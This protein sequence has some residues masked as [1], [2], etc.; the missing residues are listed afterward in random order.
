[1]AAQAPVRELGIRRR[2]AGSE[3][4][5]QDWLAVEAPLAIS[6]DH[7]EW[8]SPQTLTVT[9]RTPGHDAELAL[10][11][12]YAEG[13]LDL[14]APVATRL[15]APDQLRVELTGV[16]PE[17]VALARNG[18]MHGGCGVC[19]KLDA[20]ALWRL[21]AASV[22]G[23]RRLPD[24]VLRAA[25]ATLRAAQQDYA[26]TGGAHAVAL[27]DYQGQLQALREDIGRHNA[28]DKLIGAAYRAGSL[29]WQDQLLLLSGRA[30]AELIHKAWRAGA[31]VVAAIGAPS[32]LAVSLAEQAGITLIGFLRAD[33]YNVYTH[34]ERLQ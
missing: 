28:L 8:P 29:P 6:V 3:A 5:C 12:L 26:Q 31:S 22:A 24:A 15:V 10:G 14:S 2:H 34:P 21:P 11:Y 7:P 1:M 33:G 9:L 20:T 27:Y 16:P 18:P 13:V 4:A 25:P 17:L 23:T 32:T 19:G 30:S